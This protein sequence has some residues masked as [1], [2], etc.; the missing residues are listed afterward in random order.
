MYLKPEAQE[1]G[2]VNKQASDTVT[3]EQ[4]G[5]DWFATCLLFVLSLFNII[6]IMRQK[7]TN[8]AFVKPAVL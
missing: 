3:S 2:L 8:G 5:S 7:D 6:L 4:A 1:N